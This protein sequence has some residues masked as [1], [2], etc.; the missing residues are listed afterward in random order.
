MRCIIV[1]LFTSFLLVPTPVLS[2][3]EDKPSLDSIFGDLKKALG[4]THDISEKREAIK[5]FAEHDQPETA[6]FLL[7]LL[8]DKKAPPSVKKE[9]VQVLS[10]LQNKDARGLIKE[11]A[12]SDREISRPVLEAYI[13][14][15][16][17]DSRIFLLHLVKDSTSPRLQALAI[18]GISQLK[19]ETVSNRYLEAL[20]NLMKN[21]EA[22]HGVR[23]SA[24]RAIGTLPSKTA[25]PELIS[26]LSDPLLTNEARDALLR[27]TREEYWTDQEA[28]IEWWKAN[29]E[30]FQPQLMSARSFNYTAQKLTSLLGSESNFAASFYGRSIEGK[31]ILFILDTSGSMMNADR[32]VMLQAEMTGIIQS[33]SDA[34]EIGIVTFPKTRF[35]GKDFGVADKKFRERSVE[36]IEKMAPQ[37][38]TPM[39]ETLEYAFER[40]IPRHGVDTVY[41]LSDG[42][43][44]DLGSKNLPD[45]VLGLNTETDATIHTVFINTKIAPPL[46]PGQPQPPAL[47][48]PII[49]KAAKDLKQIAADAGG[50]FRTIE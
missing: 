1:L 17:P 32:I 6:S 2:Q 40:I 16:D 26:L 29:R 7:T 9:A 30:S 41:L 10:G 31:K 22:F 11:A 14:Q 3:A 39:V 24:A 33:L 5:K 21:E 45:L 28:W 8:K 20:I 25:I 12:T 23:R 47:V 19:L 44:S 50:S 49:E 13:G 35:P 18:Y 27:L 38:R 48:N 42:F 4:V 46:L 34:Y 37:G 36:F 43:P 15:G